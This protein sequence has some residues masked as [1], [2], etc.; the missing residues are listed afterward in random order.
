M[1]DVEIHLVISSTPVVALITT[2]KNTPI[3][4]MKIFEAS[5]SPKISNVSG[6]I[7]LFGIGY[8]AEM[9]GSTSVRTGR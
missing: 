4:T 1:T 2:G 7:A 8:V 5:P 3:A 9:S 6:K